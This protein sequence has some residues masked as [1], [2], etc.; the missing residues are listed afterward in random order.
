MLHITP[1]VNF[2]YPPLFDGTFLNGVA[3]LKIKV[4]MI[5]LLLLISVF[6]MML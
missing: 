2:I 4:L 5:N 3:V 1:P 6:V